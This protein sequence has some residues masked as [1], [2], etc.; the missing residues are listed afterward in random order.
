[1]RL[2]HLIWA[3]RPKTLFASV[4]PVLLGLMLTIHEY[5]TINYSIGILTIICALLLQMGT[6]MA[7]DYFDHQKGVDNEGRLGPL[8]LT[9][10]NLISPKAMKRLYQ[11]CFYLAFILGT[12]LIFHGGTWI[13]IIGIS[14]IACAYLYSAGPYPLSHHGCGELF[15]LLFFGP[16]AVWGT[17]YLQTKDPRLLPLF[18]GLG[19]GLIS[20]VLM[21]I[22]NLRDR[23]SDKKSGKITLAVLLGEKKM[24]WFILSLVLL[25]ALIPLLLMSETKKIGL[26]LPTLAAIL[27]IKNWKAIFAGPINSKLNKT[28]EKTGQYLFIYSMSFGLGLL[29]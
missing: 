20:A 14:S 2:K 21:G 8:R 28:L 10:A 15:A 13:S 7:N 4:G 24:R 26:I 19:P 22:N 9:Q 1:M 11:S 27:F 17:F 23:S 18:V 25:S 16:I 3:T 12:Y 5:N 6:N 29:L